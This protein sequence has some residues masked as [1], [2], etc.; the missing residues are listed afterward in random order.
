MP[1]SISD[2]KYTLKLS[3][4]VLK[5]LGM[6]LYSNT[7]SVLSEAV[8]NAWDA[9]AKEVKIRIDQPKDVIVI[10]DNGEGMTLADIRERYLIVGY[11]RRKDGR[12]KTRSGRHVMGRKGIGKLSLFSIADEVEIHSVKN[13]Q[14][15]GLIMRKEDIRKELSAGGEYHPTDVPVRNIK[16]ERGTK[17]ILSKLSKNVNYA[18]EPLR[19]RLAKRFSIIGPENKFKVSINGKKIG[20]QDRDYFNMIQFLWT[21]GADGK[22]YAN[23]CPNA[24]ITHIEP[25]GRKDETFFGWIGT[26]KRPSQL[27]ETDMPSNN[28]VSVLAHGKLVHENVLPAFTEGGIYI[29]Y[30]IGEINADFLDSDDA[31]DI[32]TSSRQNVKENDPRFGR[33]NTRIYEILK[34]IQN[35]WSELRKSKAKDEALKNPVIK[36]WFDG[37]K[38]PL[39]PYALNLFHTIESF[40]TD[41]D[42]QKRSLYKYGILAF[43]RMQTRQTI[44]QL[45]LIKS[46]EAFADVFQSVDEIEA[47]LFHDVVTERLAVIERLKQLTSANVLEKIL[48]RHIFENMWLLNPAWAWV[49]GDDYIEKTAKTI[50]DSIRGRKSNDSEEKGR[51]D[52]FF[53]SFS[54]KY[55][56]VELKRRERVCSVY[57][58]A[59]QADKYINAIRDLLVK[60]GK[61][62]AHIEV[63]FLLGKPVKEDDQKQVESTLSGIS[64]R[65]LYYDQIITLATD[66]YKRFLTVRDK[67]HRLRGLIDKLD[68]QNP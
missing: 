34:S 7:P 68:T 51:L 60:N 39:Q 58:L 41:D 55:V 36:E 17:I 2:H 20:V 65:I 13:R 8:A 21:I 27:K 64:G 67:L 38:Q 43:E 15:N 16:I 53:R 59:S 6:N 61:P 66:E 49:V 33:L 9:D 10:E 22:K 26:V 45:D 32:T 44:D 56:I 62:H 25:N 37:L 48:A 4:N 42:K 18:V 19:K 3:L 11:D 50:F 63:M 30:L 12:A 23:E 54:D 46:P 28:S 52:I 35:Q 40:R 57:E 29:D 5:D 24:V 47:A 31:E 1:K 14:K